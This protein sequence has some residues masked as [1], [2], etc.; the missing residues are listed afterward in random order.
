MSQNLVCLIF[1]GLPALGLVHLEPH[2]FSERKVALAHVL[3]S[4]CVLYV[5]AACGD[6]HVCCCHPQN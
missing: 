4:V 1:C 5:H 6:C 2:K 3:V